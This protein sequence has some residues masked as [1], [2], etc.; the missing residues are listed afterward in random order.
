MDGDE[1]IGLILI[2]NLRTAV[3]FDEGIGLSGIDNLH[4]GTVLLNHPS[5]SQGILQ[6]QIFLLHLALTD[7]TSITATMSSIDHQR[8]TFGLHDAGYKQQP[9]TYYY[10]S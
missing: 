9:Y 1:Q 5:E 6:R 3:Q 2:G 4:V 7:S 8:E 10:I